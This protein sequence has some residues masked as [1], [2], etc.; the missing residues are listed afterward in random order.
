MTRTL[1]VLLVI[2]IVITALQISALIVDL[3]RTDDSAFGEFA[4]EAGMRWRVYFLSAMGF[5][6]LGFVLRRRY[7][8]AGDATLIAGIYLMLLANNGGLFAS[9]NEP[10]RLGTSFLTLAFLLLLAMRGGA[11]GADADA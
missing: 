2:A 7:R 5:L 1:K 4:G 3:L 8:L 6:V 9:G 11:T 10:Y